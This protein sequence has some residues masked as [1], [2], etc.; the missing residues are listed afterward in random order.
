MSPSPCRRVC[1]SL[2]SSFQFDS[3]FSLSSLLHNGWLTR[4]ST[5]RFRDWP[6]GRF[7]LDALA[8]TKERRSRSL[9]WTHRT[10]GKEN[11]VCALTNHGLCRPS[12]DGCQANPGAQGNEPSRFT[13]DD[14]NNDTGLVSPC[15]WVIVVVVALARAFFLAR[16]VCLEH[17]KAASFLAV[18]LLFRIGRRLAQCRACVHGVRVALWDLDELVRVRSVLA[19]PMIPAR[20]VAPDA[21]CCSVVWPRRR[22][23]DLLLYDV[24][25]VLE[26]IPPGR[27]RSNGQYTPRPGDGPGAILA[28]R[29]GDFPGSLL[30]VGDVRCWSTLHSFIFESSDFFRRA[31]VL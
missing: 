23:K 24:T 19:V 6:L 7:N 15:Q 18:P 8:R 10:D 25:G 22:L 26:P 3:L 11:L 9:A 5:D 16:C 29:G 20:G 12:A 21:T 28:Q 31:L 27:S 30:E 4:K 2:L 17:S 1:G 14:L 13:L